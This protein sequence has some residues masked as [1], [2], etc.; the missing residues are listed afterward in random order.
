MVG[1]QAAACGRRHD[2]R[3]YK[4]SIVGTVE[5]LWRY[6][7]KSMAGEEVEVAFLGFA[8]VYGDRVFAFKS[9]AAPKGFPYLTAREQHQMLR[10]R[11][12]FRHPDLAAQPPNLPDVEALAPGV[13]LT[14]LYAEPA[15]LMVDVETPSGETLVVDDPHLAEMLAE[16][17][18][19]EHVLSLVHTERALTDLRPVSLLS[20]QTVRRLGAELSMAMDQRRFRANIYLDLPDSGGFAEDDFVGRSL[21]IGGRSVISILERDPRCPLITLDPDT[22]EADPAVLRQVGSAHEG[23]F[24][25][26][27]AVLVEGILRKGDSIE[28]LD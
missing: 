23:M 15:D 18:G 22:G 5:S 7:V 9:A 25:V 24:G 14:P 28:L 13:N 2:E 21:R 26:Y 16:G 20:V 6:P 4:V 11:P 19:A 10:Y 3:G 27:G 8:G 17:I 12:R 1:L